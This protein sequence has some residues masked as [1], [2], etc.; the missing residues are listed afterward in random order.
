MKINHDYDRRK[1]IPDLVNIGEDLRIEVEKV[2]PK[3]KVLTQEMLKKALLDIQFRGRAETGA[4]IEP[5]LTEDGRIKAFIGKRR[6][7]RIDCPITLYWV[8][9]VIEENRLLFKSNL[10]FTGNS[11]D[12]GEYL[13]LDLSI[14]QALGF[15]NMQQ[16]TLDY[17][18]LYIPKQSLSDTYCLLSDVVRDREGYLANLEALMGE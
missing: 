9:V 13:R 16:K 4:S 14:R 17:R 5:V 8:L 11:G 1:R 7:Y 18:I 2:R 10:L 3:D 6:S 15:A 12:S